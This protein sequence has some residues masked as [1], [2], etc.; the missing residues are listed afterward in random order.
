MLNKYDVN[1]MEEIENLIDEYLNDRDIPCSPQE[2]NFIGKIIL[3]PVVLTI[4]FAIY[5]LSRS[6]YW[7]LSTH[8]LFFGIIGFILVFI[9]LIKI[10]TLKKRIEFN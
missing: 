8:P 10:K 5:F 7:E 6:E 2:I 9:I 1:I 3:L 4:V